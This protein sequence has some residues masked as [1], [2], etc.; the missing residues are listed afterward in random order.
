MVNY[1]KGKSV[2]NPNQEREG[3]VVR[4]YKNIEHTKYGRISF[5][6]INPIYLLKY[7]E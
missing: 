5:K 6:V 2:L 3:I 7:E 4:P 1:S